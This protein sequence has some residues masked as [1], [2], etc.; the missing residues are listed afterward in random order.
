MAIW[1]LNQHPK[2]LGQPPP[3]AM[4]SMWAAWEAGGVN[5]CCGA[6]GVSTGMAGAQEHPKRGTS[7]LCQPRKQERGRAQPGRGTGRQHPPELQWVLWGEGR[8]PTGPLLQGPSSEHWGDPM[9]R[10]A[11]SWASGNTGPPCG[12]VSRAEEQCA[13]AGSPEPGCCG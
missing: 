8:S 4:G 12:R 2:F 7:Y 11:V 9:A 5:N 10:E 1:G 13:W 6:W 3:S